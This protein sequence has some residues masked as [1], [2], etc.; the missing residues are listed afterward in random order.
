MGFGV[1]GCLPVRTLGSSRAF[2][3]EKERANLGQVAAVIRVA[4]GE[5]RELIA[6][7]CCS[8]RAARCVDCLLLTRE[9]LAI[10]FRFGY[11]GSGAILRKELV[12]HLKGQAV[13]KVQQAG[14]AAVLDFAAALAHF[15]LFITSLRARVNQ[16]RA[17]K[18]SNRGSAHLGSWLPSKHAEGAGADL[19]FGA[20]SILGHADVGV[21]AQANLAGGGIVS[22]EFGVW[23]SGFE[24]WASV[25]RVSGLEFGVHL[26]DNRK[27]GVLPLQRVINNRVRTAASA[28]MRTC[29]LSAP[30]APRPSFAD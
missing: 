3:L 28:Q 26:A 27:V 2:A 24:I 12:A 10:D 15:R 20:E 9:E 23:G 6:D 17:S 22:L 8:I 19:T 1:W 25:I 13:L 4:A 11:H 21:V 30:V 7:R 5:A 14:L 18:R 29:C 16:P